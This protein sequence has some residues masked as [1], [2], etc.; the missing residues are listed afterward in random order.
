MRT[1]DL[2]PCLAAL[3]KGNDA[4]RK[5]GACRTVDYDALGVADAYAL[6]FHLPRADNLAVAPNHSILRESLPRLRDV[7]DLGSGTGSLAYA[8]AAHGASAEGRADRRIVAVERSASMAT[9]A[10]D[11]FEAARTAL[12]GR[13]SRLAVALSRP[14]AAR[15]LCDL[16]VASR[17]VAGPGDQAAAPPPI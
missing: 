13:F 15:N 6:K 10:L 12:V 16:V 7:L 14:P 3:K 11:L 8:L 2:K 17:V 1:S 4:L 9:T 5:L